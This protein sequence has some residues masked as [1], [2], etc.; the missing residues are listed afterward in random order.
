MA[1]RRKFD[2]A[3]NNKTCNMKAEPK[4]KTVTRV[5]RGENANIPPPREYLS[6][7]RPKLRIY[8]SFLAT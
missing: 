5:P 8:K 6:K 2:I 1:P 7:S 3:T 4:Q